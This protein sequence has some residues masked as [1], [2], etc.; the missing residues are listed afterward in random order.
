MSKLKKIIV[1]L[2]IGGSVVVGATLVATPK[3][4]FITAPE[5]HVFKIGVRNYQEEFK[6]DITSANALQYKVGDRFISFTPTGIY[7]DGAKEKNVQSRVKVDNAYND[8]FGSGF[9]LE[10]KTSDRIWKKLVTIESFESIGTIPQGTNELA[11]EFEID[12]NFV[13]DGWNKKSDLEIVDE[14]RLGEFSYLEQARA[15]DSFRGTSCEVVDAEEV[16]EDL[17]N[18]IA[19]R[20]VLS[21]KNGK[22]YFTKYIPVDWLKGAQY[23]VFTDADVTYGTVQTVA[24]CSGGCQHISMA[25]L[26]TDKFAVCYVEDTGNDGKCRAGSVSGTTITFGTEST[27]DTDVSFPVTNGDALG[28]A[29]ID[30]DKIAIAFSADDQADDGYVTAATVSGTTFSSWAT[31]VEFE[32]GD[33]EYISASQLDTDRMIVCYNDESNSDTATCAVITFSGTTPSAG[34]PDDVEVTDHNPRYSTTAKLATDKYVYCFRSNQTGDAHCVAATVSGTTITHGTVVAMDTATNAG[35]YNAVASLDT[36]EF[37]Y[38]NGV[39]GDLYVA[40]VSGTTITSGSAQTYDTGD[41]R[42]TSIVGIDSDRYLITYSDSGDGDDG[43]SILTTA[44]FSARTAT[45]GSNETFETDDIWNAD[46]FLRPNGS[47]L[48]SS[49][50]VAVCYSNISSLG[51]AECIIGDVSAL[52]GGDAVRKTHQQGIIIIE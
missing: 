8:I 11:I 31:Q 16:C 13:V 39:N 12:T 14:V 26:D 10:M 2:T 50:K 30:T 48:I 37:V 34:T 33:T 4:E 6:T 29:Q 17:N 27:F 51:A 23:P 35:F 20:T 1:G 36:D 3:A 38:S 19:I 21:E 24:T 45:F 41:S 46:D 52:P 22:L 43:E 42:G 32:T 47:I 18:N 40:T 49:N 28:V 9:D 5:N 15:W 25:K 44:D 7:F